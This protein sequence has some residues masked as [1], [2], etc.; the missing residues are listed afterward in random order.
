[1]S[2]SFV[3][4]DTT[5]DLDMAPPATAAQSKSIDTNAN[6]KR[7]LLL[8][9]PSI[10]A[11]EDKLRDLFNVFDRSVTDLQMLDRLSA[12][13]VS[14]S[15]NTYDNV[16]VLTDTDGARR[17][18]ALKLLTRTVFATLVPAMKVGATFKAQDGGALGAAES[19]EALLSGLV[20]KDGGFEKANDEEESVAVPLRFGNKK[21]KEAGSGVVKPVAVPAPV[22][23]DLDDDDDDD[24]IDEETLLEDVDMA[25]LN[26]PKQCLPKPG[27][28][29]RACKDCSCGLAARIRGEDA[30]TRSDADKKL[31]ALKLMSDDLNEV[32]F[33]VQG[34]TGSCNSCSLGDAFRCDGCPYRGLPAFKPGEEV[35][36]LNDVA[37]L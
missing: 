5:A 35:R 12:G 26:I 36:I 11:Q 29:A 16:L 10:S 21:N 8:A 34:K 9:P 32:D 33:T 23:I 22:T 27:R 18:E 7:T 14:L 17:P 15:P 20:E 19:R 1:M 4:I 24:L 6:T 37:E 2:P 13:F 31:S 28:R 25:S 30:A 3:T